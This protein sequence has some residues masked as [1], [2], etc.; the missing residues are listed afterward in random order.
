MIKHHEKASKIFER[1]A[2]KDTLH[3]TS[4]GTPFFDA[5]PANNHAKALEDKS[6]VK[7]ERHEV[8]DYKP[9]KAKK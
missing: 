5:N 1:H 7:V 9:A 3:F 4:D 6:V 8:G 2:K